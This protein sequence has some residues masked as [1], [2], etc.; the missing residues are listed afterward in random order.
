MTGLQ[1]KFSRAQIR[2]AVIGFRDIEDKHPRET[3]SFTDDIKVT[4]A[5]LLV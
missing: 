2:F 5:A 3:L 1:R 4:D